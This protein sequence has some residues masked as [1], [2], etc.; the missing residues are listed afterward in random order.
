M[1]VVD[2]ISAGLDLVRRRPLIMAIPLVL[3]LCLWVAPQL[4]VEP[5]I[6]SFALHVLAVPG[7]V[8]QET[9]QAAEGVRRF[10]LEVGKD[11][12]LLSLLASGIYGVP[13]VLAAGV[14]EGMSNLGGV[15]VVNSSVAAL[16]LT[17]LLALLG[18]GVA[19]VYLTGVSSA[20]REERLSLGAIVS[21]SG[22]NYVRLLVLGIAMVCLSMAVGIPVTLFL[23]LISLVSP[24]A[25]AFLASVFG[26]IVLWLI[27]WVLFYLFFVVDA[28]VLDEVGLRRA[29]ISSIIVVRSGFWSAIGFIVLLNVLAA[30]LSIVWRWMAATPLGLVAGMVANAFVGTGLAA[31]SFIFYRNRLQ[32]WRDRV[33]ELG[34]R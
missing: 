26:L 1:G 12:N 11:T 32:A 34:G 16:L 29:I 27:L 5:V 2:S 28:L 23:A 17:V 24:A 19:A 15:V 21:R 22:R 6:T 20:V 9:Y 13:T 25:S 3:D 8:D 4:S 10:L 7:M 31:A 14:P 18:V 33:A 30:G